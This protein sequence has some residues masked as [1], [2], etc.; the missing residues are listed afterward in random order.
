[1]ARPDPRLTP[2]RADLAADFLRGVV[3]AAQFVAGT[4]MRVVEEAIALR[5]HPVPDA[6]L[7][8]QALHGEEVMVY[9]DHEGWAWGQLL[10]DRYVG[11][12][13]A[14]A[15]RIAGPDPTHKICVPRSFAYPDAS[16]K[17][18]ILHAL[19]LGAK[20][21]IIESRGDFARTDTHGFIFAAHLSKIDEHAGDFVAIAE[22]FLNVPYLWGGKTFLGLDCSGLLQI[23]LASAGHMMP[24]DSDMLQA[25]AG[26]P[27]ETDD[28]LAGLRRGDLVFWKGHCGI[29]RDAQTLLHANGHHMMVASEPLRVARERILAKSFGPVTAVRRLG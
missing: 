11:Y 25:S 18:P 1:M 28:E 13:P 29:M 21:R 6:G 7:Q 26:S 24:R 2:A 20:V 23:S 22:M 15:L 27:V 16:M 3:E 14:N 9:E 4:K 10:A 12:M 19:P 5:S 8:T 17:L